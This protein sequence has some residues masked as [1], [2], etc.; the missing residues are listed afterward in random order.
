LGFVSHISATKELFQK[1]N[2]AFG[3][4]LSAVLF[5]VTIVLTGAIYGD[6]IYTLG[7]SVIAVG[8]Y[9]LLGLGLMSLTRLIFDKIALPKISISDEIIKGNITAAIVDA[10][11][12]IAT[13]IVI[14]TVMV[15]VDS[16]T[17]EGVVAVLVGYLISQIL[18]TSTTCLRAYI[19]ERSNKGRALKEEF[20]KGNVAIGLRFAGRK[21]GTAFAIVAASNILVF[22]TYGIPALLVAWGCISVVMV[23]ILS[24]L[25]YL[26]NKIILAKID[27]EDEI[28]NQH[29]IALG[30]VQFTIYLSLGMLLA[31][32]VS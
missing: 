12:V 16:N 6:P 30:A 21:I 18:L 11:N 8:L 20:T 27:V 2:T 28:I 29:N 7:D 3:I 23:A 10:G 25:S 15:W 13:A 1:D 17:I 32:L 22:D 19:Y 24:F 4:S 31:A 5:S 14:R 9:G 26:A